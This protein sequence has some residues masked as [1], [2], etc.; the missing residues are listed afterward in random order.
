MKALHVLLVVLILLVAP[1]AHAETYRLRYEAQILGLLTIGAASYEVS[2]AQGGGYAA[3]GGVQTSGVARLFDQ[4]SI[5]ASASGQVGA[6]GV[7][8]AN[9][10]L[11]HAYANKSRRVDMRRTPGDIE[12]IIA[13]RYGNMGTPPAT[14]AQRANSYDPIS[15]LFALGRQ[16]AATQS[17]SGRVLVFD[18]RQH[19]R[20]ATSGGVRGTF[21]GGG[22]QGPALRCALRYEALAGYTDLAEARRAPE[23]EAWFGLGGDFAPLLQLTIPTP[24]GPARLDLRGYER[25][26]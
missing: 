13:P 17:C 4:T 18:G 21:N 7:V 3:Q 19:Y 22:Y 5:R 12:T 26:A 11:V 14:P 9:Y 16:V 25:R 15:A 8:W 2:V 24:L 1:R 6:R 23:A 10:L 20:L